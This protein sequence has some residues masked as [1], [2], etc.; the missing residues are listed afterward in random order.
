MFL[1]ALWD[2]SDPWSHPVIQTAVILYEVYYEPFWSRH[3]EMLKDVKC[4]GSGIRNSRFG[5]VTLFFT[6]H[7]NMVGIQIVLKRSQRINWSLLH[8]LV[9]LIT[10]QLFPCDWQ[11][12]T[13]EEVFCGCCTVWLD[14]SIPLQDHGGEAFLYSTSERSILDAWCIIELCLLT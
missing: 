11:Q 6:L 4:G 8:L 5:S 13:V 1:L 12:W 9:S 14:F 7:R 2:R 3:L 10:L